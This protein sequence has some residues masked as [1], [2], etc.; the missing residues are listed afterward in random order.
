M[1][2]N[3]FNVVL[4]TRKMPSQWRKGD[5]VSSFK[6]GDPTDCG[7]YR[8]ITLLPVIDKL[9]MTILGMRIEA[10]VKLHEHQYGFVKRK[11]NSYGIVQPRRDHARTRTSWG[12]FDGVLLGRAQGV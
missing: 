4:N 1:L 8:G 3:V 11:G 10:H 5:V 12:P 2:T 9:Y 6:T 7:N